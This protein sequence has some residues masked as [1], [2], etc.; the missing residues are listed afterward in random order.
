[1]RYLEW[2][3]DFRKRNL[4]LQVHWM[5]GLHKDWFPFYIEFQLLFVVACYV[6]PSRKSHITASREA[7]SLKP[8][9][10]INRFIRSYEHDL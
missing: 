3:P 7:G 9:R 2:I 10:S 6:S 1:M 4:N 5:D 8:A